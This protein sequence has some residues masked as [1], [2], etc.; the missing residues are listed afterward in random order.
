PAAG[1]TTTGAAPSSPAAKPA[2]SPA[3]D[4]GSGDGPDHIERATVSRD[5]WT[6]TATGVGS[7]NLPPEERAE[8]LVVSAVDAADPNAKTVA[9]KVR[10]HVMLKPYHQEKGPY[11]VSVGVKPPH[12]I[13]STTQRPFE[14]FRDYN[15]GIGYTSKPVDLTRKTEEGGIYLT[16]P[17]DFATQL[18]DNDGNTRRFPAIPVANDPGDWT[19]LFYRVRGLRE[20]SSLYCTGFPV[21]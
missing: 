13:D 17:D 6:G 8:Y 2:P 5:L 9:G 4:G 7:C 14:N 1:A 11:F 21:K 15:H 16:Y 18:V 3:R 20:Y 12:E 10:I 19:V